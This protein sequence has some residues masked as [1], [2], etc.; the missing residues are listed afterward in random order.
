MK[1]VIT[2]ATG[3]IGSR[4]ALH[5]REQGME[6]CA[7]GRR[8]S[9]VEGRYAEALRR[10]GAEVLEIPVTE[11]DALIEPMRGAEFVFHLAAAQHEANVP[12]AY[13]R[14]INVEGTHHVLS[15]AEAA[16]V[17]RFVHG[18]TI[19]VYAWKEGEPVTEASPLC[20]DNIYGKTKLEGEGVV[21]S[22]AGRVPRV[23]VR[24]SETYGPGDQRLRKLFL[25]AR[26]GFLLQVGAARNLH[27]LVFID[28]LIAGLLA[29]ARVPE[30][31]GKTFV[32][33]G[34]RPV[35]SREMLEVVAAAE[36]GGA[37][38]VYVPLA[39]LWLVAGAC[40]FALRPLGI[41]PPLHRRRMD[42]FRKSFAFSQQEA[43]EILGYRPAMDLKTGM[44]RTAQ[45]YR[46]EGWL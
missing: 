22:L 23:I 37:R 29:A 34:E 33:A 6:V 5:C 4:L 7:L 31:A 43:R 28:D 38:I 25:S 8:R 46:D 18:S 24:I 45:W 12:D 15:A 35:T 44:Q 13:F 16:G 9:A 27:H 3:F 40:E 26:R 41:Q 32:L 17:A 30:A 42:F 21:R 39:P 1:V 10:A 14:E 11:P 36:G 20:P 19:G 2:G